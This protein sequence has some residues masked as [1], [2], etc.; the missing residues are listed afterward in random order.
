MSKPVLP[1]GY[2]PGPVSTGGGGGGGG[3]GAVVVGDSRCSIDETALFTWLR[4]LLTADST[5]CSAGTLGT[6]TGGT[7]TWG[8]DS[9]GR[10]GTGGSG[11]G[12]WMLGFRKVMS[13]TPGWRR[14]ASSA[15]TPPSMTAS[16]SGWS[17]ANAHPSVSTPY[18]PTTVPNATLNPSGVT[19]SCD[20][21]WH[22]GCALAAVA[23]SAGRPT[24]KFVAAPLVAPVARCRPG[25][26]CLPLLAIDAGMASNAITATPTS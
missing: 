26:P 23:G 21:A 11:A 2:W 10:L 14:T 22:A 16:R 18:V 17:T 5:G 6:V 7:V 25:P 12:V 20:A 19:C 3:G 8:T 9:G 24:G 15:G 4:T 1:A 13:T